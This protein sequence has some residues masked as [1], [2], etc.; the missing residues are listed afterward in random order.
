[1]TARAG[2]GAFLAWGAVGAGLCLGVLAAP[3]IGIFVLPVAVVAAIALLVWRRG[4]NGSFVGLVSGFG[5]IPLYVGYLNR[6][7]P[8]TVCHAIAGGQQC[9][10]EWNP[11]PWLAVGALLVAAGIAL[12]IWLRARP[13]GQAGQTAQ[14]GQGTT[15]PGAQPPG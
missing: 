1:M 8:G 11:V 15:L 10:S 2:T 9:D 6:D 12:F 3:T 13:G 4:R 14:A 5:L 7:G